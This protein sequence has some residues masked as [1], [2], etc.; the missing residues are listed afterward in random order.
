MS[1]PVVEEPEGPTPIRQPAEVNTLGKQGS[2][3]LPLTA[4]A[5]TGPT[6]IGGTVDL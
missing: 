3:L 4:S 5:A 1:E 2:A 6:G